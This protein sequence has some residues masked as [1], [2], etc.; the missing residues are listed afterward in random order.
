MY[1]A[2][3]WLMPVGRIFLWKYNLAM[4]HIPLRLIFALAM[5]TLALTLLYWG[6][7]APQRVTQLQTIQPKQMQLSAGQSAAV[8]ET[9]L[10]TLTYPATIRAGEADQMR[11]TL[12][13]QKQAQTADLPNVYETYQV[14]AEARLEMTGMNA[15]PAETVSQPMLPG[16]RVTFFWSIRPGEVG[17]FQGTLWLYLRF[18][19]KGGGTEIRQA[20]SAQT[21]EIEST[22]FLGLPADAALPIGLAGVFVSALL[23]F[24]FF[25]DGLK[26][27]WMKRKR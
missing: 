24:S 20:I 15:R 12:E 2:P 18:I 22:T 7:S 17:R 5:A 3:D 21:V 27:L 11:L 9:R 10:L 8:P 14:L 16:Q 19:P 23:G 6:L 13:A 4:R 25:A 1:F 26:W